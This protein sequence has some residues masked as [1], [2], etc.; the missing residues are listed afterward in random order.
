MYAQIARVHDKLLQVS[1]L[2]LQS[3]NTINPSIEI[4]YDN[5]QGLK[6]D[7]NLK[8]YYDCERQQ[9]Q[10]SLTDS[11]NIHSELKP[12]NKTAI[13][14]AGRRVLVRGSVCV[15]CMI[16]QLASNRR[17]CRET[18]EKGMCITRP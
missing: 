8:D 16:P 12:V 15:L 10:I 3:C 6:L 7:A 18:F 5:D 13:Y 11:R 2:R 9:S 14:Q 17:Q 4:K 1:I